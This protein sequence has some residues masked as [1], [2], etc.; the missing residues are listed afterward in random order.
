MRSKI[1]TLCN[2]EKSLLDFKRD[3]RYYDGRRNQ[4]KECIGKQAKERKGTNT[5]KNNSNTI[6]IKKERLEDIEDMENVL[7]QKEINFVKRQFK[8]LRN[9]D[10]DDIHFKNRSACTYN[11]SEKVRDILNEYSAATGIKKSYI[12]NLAIYA[13]ITK[14][15]E[16]NKKDSK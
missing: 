16:T 15:G 12:V 6:K 4:C 3:D 2:L 9:F 14:E 10:G 5:D 7:T 13:Y 1:C 11:I 8:A